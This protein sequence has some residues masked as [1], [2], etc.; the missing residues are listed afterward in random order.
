MTCREGQQAEEKTIHP[1]HEKNFKN[2]KG[3][4]FTATG[5]GLAIYLLCLFATAPAAW[6]T[7]KEAKESQMMEQTGG[8]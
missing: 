6:L 5:I 7:W 4:V 3:F 2:I 8:P 1:Q